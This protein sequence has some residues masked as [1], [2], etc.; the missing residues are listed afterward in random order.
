LATAAK[1]GKKMRRAGIIGTNDPQV[2]QSAIGGP[3][4][5]KKNGNA[6]L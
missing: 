4:L 5:V 6:L 3:S 1:N 2:E